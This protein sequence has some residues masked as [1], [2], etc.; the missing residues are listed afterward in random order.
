MYIKKNIFILLVIGWISFLCAKDIDEDAL[1]PDS[2]LT[3][4]D[5]SELKI[6]SF[7]NVDTTKTSFSGEVRS[8][9]ETYFS[10]DYFKNFERNEVSFYPLMFGELSLDVRLPAGIK[11]FVTGEIY[12]SP[13]LNDSNAFKLPEF[14]VDVNLKKRL[15]L[16]AGKQLLQWGRGFF[17]NPTDMVNVERKPFIQKIG[18]RE[19]TFGIKTHIPFGTK[20]NIYGFIDLNKPQSIDSI[21]AALRIETLTKIAGGTEAGIAV[22]GKRGKVPVG[23]F[24]F[25]TSILS[26]NVS[27]E[28][29]VTSGENYKTLDPQK[30]SII[31]GNPDDPFL[32]FTTYGRRPVVRA[33]MGFLKAFDFMNV[34]DRILVV[35]EFYF[36]QIGDDGN[37]FQKYNVKNKLKEISTM[38]DSNAIKKL[39]N[40]SLNDVFEFNSIAKYYGAF[41]ITLSKFIV[42]EMTLQLNGLVNFN[43]RCAIFTC[44]ISYLSLHNLSVDCLLSTYL[45]SEESEY[46]IANNG[47]SLRITVGMTF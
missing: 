42:S 37:I 38:S 2:V 10:R 14:F 20:Y 31:T 24:D 21:A 33:S 11:S 6:P 25:S 46:T 43:H 3:I 12:Y 22:W 15:Y 35:G 5:S 39:V 44:G 7:N 1:F 47:A 26:F 4:I 41:F 13:L 40:I 18:S 9:G 29:S 16:R 27:G 34:D 36:N 28:M 32:V 19:G 45:G 8:I 23:G 17:W 30:S